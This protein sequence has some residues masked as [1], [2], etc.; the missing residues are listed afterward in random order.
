[1]LIEVI[2]LMVIVML[3][4]FYLVATLGRLQAGAYAA[5]AAAREA[6]R[7]YVTT[8]DDA[9]APVRSQAAAQLVFT[10]HDLASGQGTIELACETSPCLSPGARVEVTAVVQVPLPLVPEFMAGSVPTSV[11]MTS[12]HSE[13]VDAFRGQ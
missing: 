5:S 6:G 3:P 2:F 8:V 1:M 11:S 4:L 10:A 13:P 9:Q 12:R 7:A